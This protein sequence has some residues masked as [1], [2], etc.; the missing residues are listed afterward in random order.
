MRYPEEDFR[1]LEGELI[2]SPLG[3][4]LLARRPGRRR[5]NP[6]T[7]PVQLDAARGFRVEEEF[8]AIATPTL[9]G[10]TIFSII[11][12]TTAYPWSTGAL[13]MG[14]LTG[15]FGLGGLTPLQLYM[16]SPGLVRGTL[17]APDRWVSPGCGAVVGVIVGVVLGIH[18]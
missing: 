11:A 3:S 4:W 1:T 12:A 16:W 13:F 15:G 2:L 6:G 7:S 14:C 17:L 9:L 8:W 10:V 18:S 5:L